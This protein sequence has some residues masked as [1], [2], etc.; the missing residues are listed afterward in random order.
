MKNPSPGSC[1]GGFGRPG[2]GTVPIGAALTTTM[3]RTSVACIA[4]TMARVPR[5]AIPASEFDLGPRPESTAS[6]PATADSSAATSGVARSAVTV[7]TCL[8]SFFGC[9]T[10]AVTSCPAATAC[11]KA[12][13]PIPPVAA[14]IVS[15][16]CCTLV[17]G[18]LLVDRLLLPKRRYPAAY[19]TV[20]ADSATIRSTPCSTA[21]ASS[22]AVAA[23]A[24]ASPPRARGLI[25][26]ALT[27]RR[28]DVSVCGCEG[29]PPTTWA[30]PGSSA[31][32]GLRVSATTF[33]PSSSSTF[34]TSRPTL[35]VAPVTTIIYY[36]PFL[37][38]SA[39]SCRLSFP[40]KSTLSA[41]MATAR[42]TPGSR[43]SASGYHR[44]CQLTCRFLQDASRGR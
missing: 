23:P 39:T 7:R 12:C 4:W 10:T 1:F 38:C 8:D 36:L 17:N 30:P 25:K 3:R 14:K 13:R 32:A 2:E 31:A 16:I 28:A 44:D 22:S 19:C 40:G 26:T 27:P 11:S 24:V 41:D 20:T 18:C 5:Q 37:Q 21:S 35:P 34:T 9:R 33:L 15:F 29:S 6:A 43:A 42:F